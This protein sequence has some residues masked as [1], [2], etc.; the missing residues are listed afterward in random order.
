MQGC[1]VGNG[2]GRGW[3]FM[4]YHPGLPEFLV[5]VASRMR[6]TR[7]CAR[8]S[9]ARS[10]IEELMAGRERLRGMGVNDDDVS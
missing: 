1:L 6:S 10:F 2:G 8:C 3:D 9:R 7:S 4:S 5:R